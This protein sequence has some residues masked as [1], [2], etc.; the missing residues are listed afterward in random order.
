MCCCVPVLCGGERK[1][2]GV[3]EGSKVRQLIELVVCNRCIVELV[4]VEE[5]YRY[6]AALML[7]VAVL[8][9]GVKSEQEVRGQTADTV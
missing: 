8:L 5:R 1:A 3:N 6:C 9:C 2:E 4:C 7:C